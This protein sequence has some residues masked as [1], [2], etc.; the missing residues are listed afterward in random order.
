M[1]TLQVNE[2]NDTG[3]HSLLGRK[4][5]II[6]G[7]FDVWQRGTGAFA[8]GY[9]C[10][11]FW[12]D[13][14][15][16]TPSVSQSVFAV[17]QSDVPNNPDYYVSWTHTTTGAASERGLFQQGV[18]SVKSFAN[19]TVTLS[20]Y[21]KADSTRNVAVEFRQYFGSSGGSSDVLTYGGTVS[22]TTSWKKHT[23]T[24]T[25]PSISGK[26]L[27]TG[28]DDQL[29]VSLWFT[30]GSDYNARTN[31]LGNQSGTFD[32]AQVQLEKGSVATEFERRSYGEELAL[33]Q[34]YYR[35][36]ECLQ[37]TMNSDNTQ[38]V[39]QTCHRDMRTTPTGT[40][41]NG[42]GRIHHPGVSFYDISSIV[43]IGPAYYSF[44]PSTLLGAFNPAQLA[45]N[46]IGLDAEL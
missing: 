2:I 24:V 34:R 23:V 3:G 7:N 39:T 25:L 40:I 30:A 12:M 17:G 15:S 18:E 28:G 21:A 45:Q 19:E 5:A 8:S 42:G 36:N 13:Y 14:S 27:G 10:D 32:I 33:C 46:S 37:G 9:T 26:T 20:F 44:T 29:L 11:R 6:N 4:N 43:L 22:L 1:S 41:V 38:F 31:S 35:L 16:I